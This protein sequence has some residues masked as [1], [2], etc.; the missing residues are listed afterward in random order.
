MRALSV[1]GE[2]A[3][4]YISGS[5]AFFQLAHLKTTSPGLSRARIAL[6]VSDTVYGSAVGQTVE[7][8]T[9]LNAISA[10]LESASRGEVSHVI[11]IR[12]TMV[13]AT[14]NIITSLNR[15]SL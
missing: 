4:A 1:A 15:S 10:T 9:L 11:I 3:R 14:I 7:V 8:T 12:F 13:M 5:H 6:T 2:V